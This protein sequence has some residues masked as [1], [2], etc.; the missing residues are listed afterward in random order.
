MQRK[1]AE[2][3][4]RRLEDTLKQA[5]NDTLDARDDHRLDNEKNAAKLKHAQDEL[6]SLQSDYQALDLGEYSSFRVFICDASVEYV[7]RV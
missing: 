4:A 5:E 6:L 7:L 1:T 3:K 2:E